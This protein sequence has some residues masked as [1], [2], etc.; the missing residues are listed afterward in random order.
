[1]DRRGMMLR[2]GAMMAVCLVCMTGGCRETHCARQRGRDHA[3]DVS[4]CSGRGSATPYHHSD[5]HPVPTRPA[6][7]PPWVGPPSV[8]ELGA[9]RSDRTAEP[10]PRIPSQQIEI[11]PP[12]LPDEPPRPL[13]KV[14][15]RDQLFTGELR[16]LQEGSRSWVFATPELSRR[17][18]VL[19][20]ARRSTEPPPRVRR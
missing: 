10:M 3:G 17:V 6:L 4:Q 12:P 15:D 7:A 2:R 13:P 20:E 14:E 8:P 19:V 5:F 16:P 18:P 9:V 1:V 11:A